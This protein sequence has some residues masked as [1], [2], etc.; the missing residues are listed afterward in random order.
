MPI[1]FKTKPPTYFNYQYGTSGNEL[2]FGND[3]ADWIDGGAGND[4]IFGYGGSDVLRGGAGNDTLLGGN[5]DD[6]L[7]GDS[8]DDMLIGGTGRDRL[9]GGDGDDILVADIGYELDTFIGGAGIDTLSFTEFGTSGVEIYLFAGGDG[10][11]T[12]SGIENVRGSNGGD[13]IWGDDGDNR[14]EGR[15]GADLL[16]G[17]VGNDTILG[18]EGNDQLYGEDGDDVFIGDKGQD[19]IVGG[20]GNDTYV[21]GL[22]DFGLATFVGGNGSDTISFENFGAVA[23]GLDPD[24]YFGARTW[25]EVENIRGSNGA[26]ELWGDAG[27]NRI[28]GKGGNDALYGQDGNDILEGGDGYD[29]LDGGE[30]DDTFVV[31]LE[32]NWDTFI[33]GNGSDTISFVNFDGVTI[34]LAATWDLYYAWDSIENVTGSNGSDTI[35][36]DHHDNLIDGAAGDDWLAGGDGYDTFVFTSLA[37]GNDQIADFITGVDRIALSGADFGI[38]SLDDVDFF[39]GSGV[40]AADRAALLYDTDTGALSYDADGYGGADAVVFATLADVPELS[41]YDLALI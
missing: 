18:G 34:D 19:W 14:L 9:D 15:G 31:D 39:A 13:T 27:A 25:F 2:L 21:A 38:A 6:S 12:W 36:G 4:G 35:S 7:Y 28:E 23:F 11:K 33:G 24:V 26:D 16:V 8:D 5:G 32:G 20:E 1:V 3:A 30:G 22:Q 17:G 41:Q 37:N 10:Y 29:A 40:Q